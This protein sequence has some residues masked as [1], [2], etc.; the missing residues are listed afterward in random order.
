VTNPEDVSAELRRL[1]SLVCDGEL[2]PEEHARLEEILSQDASARAFY[3]ECLALHGELAWSE[4]AR[5]GASPLE[6]PSAPAVPT[7]APRNPIL[8]FLE[9]GFQQATHFLSRPPVLTLLLT[10]GL[11]GILMLLLLVH[12]G[13]QPAPENHIALQPEERAEVPVSVAQVTQM[14]QCLWD[15]AVSVGSWLPA[16]RQ[17]RLSEGFVELIF[18][19]GAKVL[20][21]GPATFDASGG[22]RGFLHD[23]SLVASVPKGSEGFAIQTPTAT[24][25]DLGT[26]FGVSVEDKKG[27]T[28]V[29]V[30]QGRVEL[31]A[32]KEG[33]EQTPVRR[34]VE[35]G[36]AVRV[37]PVDHSGELVVQEIASTVDRFVRH[38]PTPPI[39]P[40]AAEKPAQ[41]EPTVVANFSGG[42]GR[43]HADQYPGMYGG[44]WAGGWFTSKRGGMDLNVSLEDTKP[45]RGG[46][47]YLRVLGVWGL[48]DKAGNEAKVIN[49]ALV[50]RIIPVGGFENRV[51]IA[52]PYVVSFDLRVDA[53]KGFR[54]K[55]DCI[56]IAGDSRRQPSTSPTTSWTI[57]ASGSDEPEEAIPPRHWRFFNGDGRGN[58]RQVDSG[59][60]MEQGRVY[61]FRVAVDP[62]AK[63]WV[64]S[65]AVDGQQPKT[66]APMGIRAAGTAPK[67]VLGSFLKFQCQMKGSS[68]EKQCEII[69]FSID[70]V[71]VDQAEPPKPRTQ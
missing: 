37:A 23:G 31:K 8:G 9:A 44:G 18:A 56:A 20:L 13:S 50:R 42:H 26:E 59:I 46:G 6:T 63:T 7:T 28:E 49:G 15:E 11:P 64:P 30:F 4:V 45:I 29:Q 60:K 39:K 2:S 48:A 61:S 47:K 27:A 62:R 69:G 67:S 66:F 24:V 57:R 53:L 25:V 21:K 12:I 35:A 19:D 55:Y 71:V 10:I 54:G 22:G 3:R 17:L 33:S 36:R 32:G 40:P 41:L 52:K 65:I 5:R 68:K 70:S 1:I 38:L 34:C 43:E 51:D 14:H 58:Y 16:G